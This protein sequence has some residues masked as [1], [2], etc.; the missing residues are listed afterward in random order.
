MATHA[1]TKLV[2]YDGQRPLV[3]RDSNDFDL[4][5]QVL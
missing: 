5:G 2:M 1:T 4:L 3:R